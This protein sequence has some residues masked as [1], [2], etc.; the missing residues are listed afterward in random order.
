MSIESAEERLKQ[1]F[2][3]EIDEKIKKLQAKIN[4]FNFD[5][6]YSTITSYD[7]QKP[8]AGKTNG[9]ADPTGERAVDIAEI[10]DTANTIYENYIKLKE[11]IKNIISKISEKDIFLLKSHLGVI[12]V[13]LNTDQENRIQQLLKMLDNK[14]TAGRVLH[15]EDILTY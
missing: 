6:Y 13:R 15:C 7:L 4:E 8:Y 10:K 3:G 14:I 5:D 9:W 12:D 1:Y 2:E 11:V